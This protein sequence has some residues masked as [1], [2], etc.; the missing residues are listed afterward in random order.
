MATSK[1]TNKKLWAVHSWVGLYAGI[2][3]A[4]LSIT[5]AAAV[6]KNEIDRLLN[7]SLLIVE[8]RREHASLTDITQ[9]VQQ[10]YAGFEL[11]SIELPS[12]PDEVYV[13]KLRK[14]GTSRFNATTLD[15]MVNPYTGEELGSRDFYRSFAFFLRNLHVRLYEHYWGRQIVGLFGIA[16]IVSTVTGLLIYGSFMKK[17][18]FG[19]I[20]TGRGIRIVAAD[21]HKFVG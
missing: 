8:P 13:L 5:G 4:V 1:E 14:E 15:V 9:Q 7:P 19:S 17:Q 10:R 20:R 12:A 3:I 2:V 6:F 16:L 21:W 11:L 18:F